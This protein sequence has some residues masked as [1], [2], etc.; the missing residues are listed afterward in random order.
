MLITCQYC[1]KVNVPIR[2]HGKDGENPYESLDAE[3]YF[4]KPAHS[5]S[6]GETIPSDHKNEVYLNEWIV[7]LKNNYSVHHLNHHLKKHGF[8][9]AI[10][11]HA[12]FPDMFIVEHPAISSRSKRSAEFHHTKLS[13]HQ[14][15]DWIE[16]QQSRHREKRRYRPSSSLFYRPRTSFNRRYSGHNIQLRFVDPNWHNEWYLGQNTRSRSASFGY[17][18][19][20][21][22]NPSTRLDLHV[23]PVWKKGITGKGI[24]VTVLDDGLEWNNTDIRANYDPKASTDLNGNDNDPMPR[25]DWSNENKHGTRCAGEIAMVANNNFCGV[26]VAFDAKIGGVRMLDGRVTDRIEAQ[27]LTHALDHIDIFSASW[28]P[29]DDGRTVEGPGV[30]ASEAFK[31]GV[32]KGR[33]GRGVIYVWASGNGGRLGD[34]CDCDGYTGS[35]YTISISSASQQQQSPWYAEKCASTMAT[36]YS[37]GRYT[38]PKITTTDIHNKCTNEHTGTSASAP[39]AA[40]VFALV[41]QANPNLTWRDMQHLVAWTS[42]YAPLS[43]NAGWKRNGAGFQVNSRFGFGLLDADKLVKY[44]KYWKR[45]PSKSVCEISPINFRPIDIHSRV[46]VEIEM[47]I[48]GCRGESNEINFLE[49]VQLSITLDYTRR[50]DLHVNLTSPSNTETMM[51]SERQSD[52]SSSGF[53]GWSFMSVHTW[54]ENPRGKWRLEIMDRV[55]RFKNRG[56][57]KSFRIVL[58]GTKKAPE[59]YSKGHRGYT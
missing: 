32:F 39:L 40:G 20:T 16:Q 49:H 45:V 2:H 36:T 35:I 47:N 38:D 58:H 18:R 48:S 13:S 56:Q 23:M 42:D 10:D 15:I 22:N 5:S 50:G 30:L 57:L 37:S 7:K 6:D 44:A 25:Y 9:N 17:L 46:A 34:N 55:G 24:V 14:S 31:L 53:K 3:T 27:A 8:N 12:Y 41:L 54:G 52:G 51:L 59:V 1:E 4:K 26:G 33:G 28:G 11:F 21:N 43:R 29:N 19:T